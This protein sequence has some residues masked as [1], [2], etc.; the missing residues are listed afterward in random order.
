[1]VLLRIGCYISSPLCVSLH[2]I[3]YFVSL[4]TLG[5]HVQQGYCSSVWLSM[6]KLACIVYLTSL[7][8]LNFGNN[9]QF[10]NKKYHWIPCAFP[11]LV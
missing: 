9:Y 3:M 11:N 4:I 7:E 6:P 2:T 8:P 1:M 10:Q 5:M